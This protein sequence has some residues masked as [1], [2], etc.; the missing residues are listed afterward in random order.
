MLGQRARGTDG[1]PGGLLV[2]TDLSG[3][4]SQS[5][6]RCHLLTSQ[7]AEQTPQEVFWPIC[8][9]AKL[10]LGWAEEACAFQS[11]VSAH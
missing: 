8:C 11:Q 3:T 2:T 1:S 9:S 7:P 6:L 10:A 5:C 4:R